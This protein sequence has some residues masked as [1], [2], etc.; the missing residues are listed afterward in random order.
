MRFFRIASSL[1]VQSGLFVIY[2]LSFLFPRN[3][4]IWLYGNYQGT[5]RDNAKYLFI[6]NNIH[7]PEIKHVWISPSQEVVN[8]LNLLGFT[9]FYR[10]SFH[11]IYYAFIAK[12]YIYNVV[13]RDIS[14]GY[15]RGTAFLFNL[16]HGVPYKKIE[17]DIEK[18]PLKTFFHPVG[19]KE[20][21][22]RFLYE[23][24]TFRS[25]SAVLATSAKLDD[26]F[27]SAFRLPKDKV[28]IGPYPRNWPLK[29]SKIELIDFINKYETKGFNQLISSL[30]AFN[31]VII[32]MPTFRDANPDFMDQAI[33]DFEKLNYFC[34]RNN[35]L[36]LIKAHVL[37]KFSAD[38]SKFSN[39]KSLDSELDVYPLLPFTHAL[40][41]DYSSIIFDYSLLKKK[42]IFYAF[43]KEDYLSKS[44]ES[45][46]EYEEIFS[47]D[48]TSSFEALL[49]EIELLGQNEPLKYEYPL[50]SAFF[51][52][53]TD[54]NNI[55]H[56][57][58]KSIN[59]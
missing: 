27:S 1:I 40:V 4:K 34:K 54:L 33:P 48:I 11:A 37:T 29:F 59:Y 8:T 46:F 52:T 38:L 16:W 32:Y 57:I 5:F 20:K 12:V 44:R 36:F 14:N 18:G 9:S 6:Y 31:S 21:F 10:Y 56:Y 26:I 49:K 2:Y 28:C 3:K 35:T 41:S 23:P 30:S 43:D 39:I 58:K 45:Y 22:E 47:N 7:F 17:Y 55:V 51:D 53:N 42:I 13:P 24:E 15:Y 19:F 25:S 50:S